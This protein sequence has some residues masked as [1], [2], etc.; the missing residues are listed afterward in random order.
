[1]E[2]EVVQGA[3]RSP[4]DLGSRKSRKLREKGRVPGVL[5]GADD[6]K[7]L[8]K[9]LVTID[10]KDVTSLMRKK[11]HSLENTLCHL[12]LDDG[13][14]HVVLPRQLQVHPL[15]GEPFSLNFLKYR[16]GTRLD[17]P[18]EFVNA[19]ASTD[20]KRGSTLL[21]ILKSLECICSGPIPATIKVDLAN[22]SKGDI[23]RLSNNVE[24]PLGVKPA[25]KVRSDCVIGVVKGSRGK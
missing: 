2:V 20:L 19:E 25:S 18:L 21:K 5:Y 23:L 8:A 10:S 9:Y 7:N 17:I 1:M 12:V 15:T 24:L 3:L 4:K 11:K 14:K 13:S 22:V 6:N 16:P